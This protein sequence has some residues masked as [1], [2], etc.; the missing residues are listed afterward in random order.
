MH[1]RAI[2]GGLAVAALTAGAAASPITEN[3]RTGAMDLTR[4]WGSQSGPMKEE[5]HTAGFTGSMDGYDLW[6]HSLNMPVGGSE[7]MVSQYSRTRRDG[8][9]VEMS[10]SLPLSSYT[11][12]SWEANTSLRWVFTLE[13]DQEFSLDVDL[14]INASNVADP[15]GV[16]GYMSLYRQGV[17]TVAWFNET[18][19]AE[20]SWGG[21]LEAGT[22]TLNM[23]IHGTAWYEGRSDVNMVLDFNV[24]PIPGP[25]TALLLAGGLIAPRRRRR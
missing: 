10:S 22:Y 19:S 4:I 16:S 20:E 12:G 8:C 17:G 24:P 7:G 5:T 21:V 15:D 6:N 2:I 13:S 11:F 14:D 1:L 25:A 18:E 3:S 9:H 23:N